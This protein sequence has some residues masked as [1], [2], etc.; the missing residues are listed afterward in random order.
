MSPDSAKMILDA[1]KEGGNVPFYQI[2]LALYITGD[3]DGRQ[4]NKSGPGVDGTMRSP[5]MGKT[6]SDQDWRG[7]VRESAIMVGASK[8]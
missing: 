8:T 3:L 5:R 6:I 2:H 1:V 7:R 4:T